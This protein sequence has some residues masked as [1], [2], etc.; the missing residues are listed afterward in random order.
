LSPK[1][2][3]YPAGVQLV[4]D[5][6]VTL[7]HLLRFAAD[8]TGQ[9]VRADR[10]ANGHRRL[11]LFLCGL[12]RLGHLAE[13]GGDGR[14]EPTSSD[15]AI[16]LFETN[17]ATTS[18]VSAATLVGF[19]FTEAVS[20]TMMESRVIQPSLESTLRSCRCSSGSCW[21]CGLRTSIEA[22]PL[23]EEVDVDQAFGGAGNTPFAGIT[24]ALR[25]AGPI[26]FAGSQAEV[27]TLWG[28]A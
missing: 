2:S 17:A 26:P 15:E 21:K 18:A 6:Q 1:R 28:G 13:L 19:S 14:D 4:L 27:L 12:V 5:R 22:P 20:L 24:T 10:T 25:P 16:W 7:E 23:K 11:E 9:V 3:R 8:Q